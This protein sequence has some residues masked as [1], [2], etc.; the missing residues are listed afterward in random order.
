MFAFNTVKTQ[1]A[2][3]YL[4]NRMHFFFPLLGIKRQRDPMEPKQ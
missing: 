4:A 1:T 2:M 3:S